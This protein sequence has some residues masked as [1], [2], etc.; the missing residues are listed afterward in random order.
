MRRYARA[1]FAQ[2]RSIRQKLSCALV[3][4]I[5]FFAIVAAPARGD[6]ARDNVPGKVRPIPPAGVK[7]PAADRE[8]LHNGLKALD[9]LIE[10]LEAKADERT[11]K[12]LPD[13]QIFAKAVRWALDYN[14]FQDVKDVPKAYAALKEGRERAEQLLVGNAP[15]DHATGLVVRGYVSKIDGSVQPY[16]LVVPDTFDPK[17]AHIHPLDIWFHGRNEALTELNFIAERNHSRGQFTPPGTIVLHP[18][19]RYCTAF[20]FAGETDVFEALKSVDERYPIDRDRIAVRGFSMGGAATWHFAVHYPGDWAAA[21][22]GAGF[23]ETPEFLRIFQNEIL[24][25]TDY[26]KKLLHLYDCTDW[27]G[28]LFNCPTVAYSGEIDTQKQAADIMQQAMERE[29]LKLTYIIGPQTKHAYHPE[30]A[31]IVS[32]LMADLVSKGRD[33]IP[34]EIHFT[35]YT[36]KYNQ[37]DWIT[38]DALHEHWQRADV[39]ATVNDLNTIEITTKNVAALTLRIPSVVAPVRIDISKPGLVKI[40]GDEIP[41]GRS[42][43][44]DWFW[45]CQLHRDA[46]GKWLTG[47]DSDTRVAKR[48]DLQGPIDDAFLDAFVIVRPT[49]HSP[50]PKFESWAKSEM[51]R[52]IHEWR[53]QFRGDARVIDD[54]QLTD[55][56]IAGANLVLWGDP[57]SNAVLHRIADKLPIGWSEKEVV[58]GERRFPAENHAVIMIC[59]NPLNPKRYVVLNS[60]FTYREYDYLNNA[61]QIPKLPDWAIVDLDTPPDSQKPGKIVAADF[62]DEFWRLKK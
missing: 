50:N 8:Q 45:T 6:G 1:R 17:A 35:T 42:A 37:C 40:D 10:K 56:D 38:I 5:W 48:H 4:G 7:I 30:S 19:G 21:N 58:A 55:A 23:A 27:A 53:R 15:W 51:G 36:L 61:R 24:T 18:Y 32:R 25:P 33:R 43:A 60:G 47:P 3:A 28:N 52:A 20:K 22:P 29:G 54:T 41:F 57:T 16:G 39:R 59:P 34:K 12:L 9:G 44:P 49:G 2:A 46:H 26:E 13:V 14:E 62:F 11:K 31:K